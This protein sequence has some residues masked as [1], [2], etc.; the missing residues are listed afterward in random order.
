MNVNPLVYT[1]IMDFRA[2]TD[3]LLN[4]FTAAEIAAR[5][6]CSVGAVKQARL[7]PSYDGHRP[8]P[9]G[10]EEP[11]RQMAREKAVTLGNLAKRI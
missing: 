2:V 7:D 6:G 9:P 8:P 11:L 1:I 5:I 10:W 4:C 3:E